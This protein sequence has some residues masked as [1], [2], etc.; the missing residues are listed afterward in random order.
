MDKSDKP[1][2][3]KGGK[4]FHKD[5]RA[6]GNRTFRRR[7]LEPGVEFEDRTLGVGIVRKVTEDGITVAFGDVEKVIPRRKGMMEAG[8]PNPGPMVSPLRRRYLPSIPRTGRR[9]GR[10][11][12][13][14][15]KS[16]WA[17]Q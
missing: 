16:P 10:E 13:K 12:R 11:I 15:M 7:K 17:L 2:H 14:E 9:I 8:F 5:R 6:N 1:F 4:P 3:R